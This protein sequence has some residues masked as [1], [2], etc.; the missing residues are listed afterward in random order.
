MNCLRVFKVYTLK[1]PLKK[2]LRNYSTIQQET[3]HLNVGT[4]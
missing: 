3:I 4:A 2:Y 1:V